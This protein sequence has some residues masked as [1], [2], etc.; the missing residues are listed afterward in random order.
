MWKQIQKARKEES[1]FTLIELLIVIVILGILAAVVVFAVGG[2]TNRGQA[3]ACASDQ[4]NLQIAVEAYIA[5]PSGNGIYPINDAAAKTAVVP[6][7]LH[8]YPTTMVYTEVGTTGFTVGGI[9]ACVGTAA[10]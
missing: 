1:G 5:S 2:I 6:G 9:G 8:S 3:S 10:S 7:F 4:R